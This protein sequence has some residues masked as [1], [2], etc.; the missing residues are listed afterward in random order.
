MYQDE[1]NT[2]NGIIKYFLF[3]LIGLICWLFVPNPF[4][5]DH[6]IVELTD[7]EKYTITWKEDANRFRSKVNQQ[8]IVS[9]QL[10]NGCVKI[11]FINWCGICGEPKRYET[12]I[13]CGSFII[14]N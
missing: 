5:C 6:S 14:S 7:Y 8:R 2:F 10:E 11:N 13:I 12:E 4:K 1:H 9:Y 3:L